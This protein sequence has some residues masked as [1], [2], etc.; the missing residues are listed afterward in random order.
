MSDDE[1]INYDSI[2]KEYA[3]ADA[4]LNALYKKQINEFKDQ[5]ADFYGQKESRDV[6]L[7]KA[8]QVWI[9]MRDASCDYETYESKTGTGF[10]SIY[11]KCQLDKTNERIIYL[12][13]NG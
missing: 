11:K 10:S 1:E 9:K 5:G 3:K 13:D 2:S 12:K 7:K 4:E 6:F 8:Q